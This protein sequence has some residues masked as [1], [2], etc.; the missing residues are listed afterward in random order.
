M[1]RLVPDASVAV[2]WIVTE[3]DSLAAETLLVGHELHAPRLMVSEIAN[4]L[5]SKV[6][7]GQILQSQT[8]RLIAS[9][10]E[11]PV[12]WTDDGILVVN[13]LSIA[14]EVN[15]PVYDCIYLALAYRIDATVVTADRRFVNALA[16]TEHAGRVVLLADFA[17]AQE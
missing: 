8:D 5:W 9:A 15:H 4:A 16:G 13:A 17:A 12:Q 14:V 7:R 3:E 2:K 10:T 11:Q 1:A 6:R